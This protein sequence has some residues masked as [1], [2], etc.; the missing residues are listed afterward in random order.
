MKYTACLIRPISA[1][2][3]AAGAAMAMP[4][5]AQ[6]FDS[7]LPLTA[8][9]S[10][11]GDLANVTPATF[12]P[13]VRN[14]TNVNNARD[15]AALGK[16]AANVA[17]HIEELQIRLLQKAMCTAGPFTANILAQYGKEVELGCSLLGAQAELNHIKQKALSLIAP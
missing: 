15:L 2:L 12:L 16:Q 10:V 14:L 8:M 4:A 3:A 6:N 11:L 17:L 5:M 7:V 1:V 13:A 9:T